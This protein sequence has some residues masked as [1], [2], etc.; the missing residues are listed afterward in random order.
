VEQRGL[1]LAQDG[2]MRV[3]IKKKGAGSELKGSC[4]FRKKE[5]A[6]RAT[7]YPLRIRAHKLSYLQLAAKKKSGREVNQP[8]KKTRDKTGGRRPADSRAVY[9]GERIEDLVSPQLH[10]RPAA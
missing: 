6:Q 2:E 7:S 3:R 9:R 1:R 10:Q 5:N 8:E 4:Q